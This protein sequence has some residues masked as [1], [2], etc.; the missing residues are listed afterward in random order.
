MFKMP[1]LLAYS[2]IL[3]AFLNLVSC[4]HEE[5]LRSGIR[6]GILKLH[7]DFKNEAL[8]ENTLDY[9]P[10]EIEEA[11]P[12]IRKYF[13]GKTQD[14]SL[15]TQTRTR[16]FSPS[17]TGCVVGVDTMYELYRNGTPMAVLEAIL[18]IICQLSMN[19]EVCAGAIKGYVPEL[20]YLATHNA[21]DGSLFCAL[22]L[23][24]RCGSWMDVYS[25]EIDF[26]TDVPKPPFVPPVP[27]KVCNS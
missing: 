20:T 17:C 9:F 21:I 24:G 26:P 12:Q 2:L 4:Y 18:N 22:Q 14:D 3:V 16:S 5:H 1:S 8:N 23:G 19:K 25:W 10:K 11:I 13:M 6:N 27:P 15:T 7:D